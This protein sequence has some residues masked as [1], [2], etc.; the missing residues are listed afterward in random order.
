MI[1]LFVP[2]RFKFSYY[3]NLPLMM[4][5]VVQVQ[6]CSTK[7]RIFPPIMAT[8]SVSVSSSLNSNIAI[9]SSTGQNTQ[10]KI[11]KRR[12]NEGGTGICLR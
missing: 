1:S 5:S 2:E 4:S 6:R 11:L 7:L 12:P 9:C 10:L 3:A 8:C